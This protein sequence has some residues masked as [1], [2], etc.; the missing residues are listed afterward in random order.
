MEAGGA[1]RL[2]RSCRRGCEA[3]AGAQGVA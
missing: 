1:L 3:E 2:G